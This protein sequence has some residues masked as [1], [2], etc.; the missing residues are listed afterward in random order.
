[1]AVLYELATLAICSLWKIK[2]NKRKKCFDLLTNILSCHMLV[3][4]KSSYWIWWDHE[5]LVLTVPW[6]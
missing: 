1:L 3:L 5:L 4:H 2:A 6:H